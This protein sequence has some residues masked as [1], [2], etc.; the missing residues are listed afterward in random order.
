MRLSMRFDPPDGDYEMSPLQELNIG[1]VG[2]CGRGSSFKAACDALPNVAIHAVCDTNKADLPGAA[3]RLGAR[4]AY[5][6][7][8]NMIEGSDI[9]A[10]IIG[11][12]MPCHV[13]QAIAALQHD[14][15]VLSEVP[16]G[17]SVEEFR[18]LVKAW[19]RSEGLY[20]MAENYTYMRPNVIIRGLVE[21]GLMGTP[22]YAEG[23]YIH[24]LKD[25]NE[26][27]KW[28]RNWQTGINGITYG[29]HSLGP[30]L[31][32]MRGDRV[33]EA[34]C[35]GSGHHYRDPRG[36]EYENEDSCVM[37]GKMESGGLVKIRVDMLSDRPHAMTNYQLQGTDGCYESARA[38]GEPNRIWLRTHDPDAGAWMDLEDL[39]GDFLPEYWKKWQE[40]AHTTGHGGGDFFELLD[41]IDAIGEVRPCPIGMHRAMDMTLPGLISQQSI[42]E[43]GKWLEV[44]D[45]REW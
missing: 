11:T 18:R 27:T 3:E 37:L 34:C 1:V 25:L 8:E 43:G 31:Q 40:I 35:A 36:D 21:E 38:P 22:Y 20:M 26:V 7:Y 44:P 17:V 45:S 29:T 15:H 5:A 2:A 30:I 23:E 10:V 33:V 16:A 14:L 39:P 41:F 19:R 28:R 12:P 9:D 13:P 24:E 32:W 6:K 4:E 42:N